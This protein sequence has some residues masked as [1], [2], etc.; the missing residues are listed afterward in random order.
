M[1]CCIKAGVG[2]L[3]GHGLLGGE[4]S[5]VLDALESFIPDLQRFSPWIS[6]RWSQPWSI[7]LVKAVVVA[8]V[9]IVESGC[10]EE[11]C[12]KEAV[13][14]V[15]DVVLLT[16]EPWGGQDSGVQTLG[17]DELDAVAAGADGHVRRVGGGGLGG[18][19]SIEAE[20]WRR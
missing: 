17:L 2:G 11:R 6:D 20:H 5:V 12:L 4:S 14:L 16:T 8:V 7:H 13:L 19:P 10:S 15:R 3:N 18:T 1:D 9:F